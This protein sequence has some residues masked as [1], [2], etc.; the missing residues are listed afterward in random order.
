MLKYVS[1]FAVAVLAAM[2]TSP[3]SAIHK[4]PC[5]GA[6]CD[7]GG[8]P[9]G[10]TLESLPCIE[11]Q[12]AKIVSGVWAC[13]ADVDTTIP[14]TDTLGALS[15]LCSP[16]DIAK[17][18]GAVWNCESGAPP[19]GGIGVLVDDDGVTIGKIVSITGD[20]TSIT[21]EVVL[22]YPPDQILLRVNK[23]SGEYVFKFNGPVYF[24]D[25]DGCTGVGYFSGNA[26]VSADSRFFDSSLRIGF[27]VGRNTIGDHRLYVPSDDSPISVTTFSQ[28]GDSCN[29]SEFGTNRSDAIRAVLL[30]PDLH[31]A[32]PRP[33]S[34][35]LY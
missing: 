4:G 5:H 29:V 31:T 30:E 32:L 21:V 23:V 12:V 16:G 11:G 27:A 20:V 1:A 15:L 8:E 2:A 25:P 34:V 17:F 3:A 13:A 24:E 14:D 18:D 6:G 26:T 10:A 22:D 33:F 28:L 35:E 9:P 7:G 19:D